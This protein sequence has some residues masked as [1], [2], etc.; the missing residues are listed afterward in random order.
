MKTQTVETPVQVIEGY[1]PLISV[2]LCPN[3]AMNAAN[4]Q[5]GSHTVLP[6]GRCMVLVDWFMRGIPPGHWI[7]T[8][9]Y[10]ENEGIYDCDLW[11]AARVR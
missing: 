5:H 2:D 7:I 4:N 9:I 11:V 6:D 3:W 10:S 8:Y 1:V